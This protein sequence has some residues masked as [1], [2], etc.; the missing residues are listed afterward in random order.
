MRVLSILASLI[1]H[2]VRLRQFAEEEE[3]LVA[4]NRRLQRELADRF[5]P[6]NIIGTSREMAPVYEMID[7]VAGSDATVLIRGRAAP[8]RSSSPR[9]STT[10]VPGPRAP[11]SG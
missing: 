9:P 8:A 3:A 2:T 10:G 4:E 5:R 6:A 1:A 11:S 7:Q